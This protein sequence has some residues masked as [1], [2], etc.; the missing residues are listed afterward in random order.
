VNEETS[1]ERQSEFVGACYD[2]DV[3]GDHLS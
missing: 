3:C 1:A 2:T